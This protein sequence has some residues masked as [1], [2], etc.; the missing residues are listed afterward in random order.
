MIPTAPLPSQADPSEAFFR[1]CVQFGPDMM[2]VLDLD[3][4]C[5]QV[6]HASNLLLGRDPDE[7][8]GTSLRDLVME[9]DQH[10]VDDLLAGLVAGRSSAMAVFRT[11]CTYGTWAWVEASARR[12]PAGAGAVLSLRDISARKEEEAMLI[13]ANDLLRRRATLD[14]VTGLANRG[15]FTAGL[16]RE[17]RRAYREAQPL[18]LLAVGIDAMRLFNDLYGRD[19]GD[20]ALREVA[21]AVEV[22]LAR[23]GDLAGRIKGATL[24]VILPATP[25]SGAAPVAERLRQAV[26]DLALEHAGVPSRRLT[27]TVG[28]ACAGPRATAGAL[29]HE[30]S[31][32]MEVARAAQDACLVAD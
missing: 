9:T 16:Q 5:R 12:L 25:L 4:R 19:A 18:A 23:P 3:G 11:R 30:A 21:T 29:M 7:L 10:I 1:Q 32:E 2:V 15:H 24:G 31:C 27:V 14:P 22:A 26:A 17:L 6:S 20:V 13:E 8:S 28:F